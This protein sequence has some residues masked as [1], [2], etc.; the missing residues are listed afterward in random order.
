MCEDCI[1]PPVRPKD[2]IL[3]GPFLDH[4]HLLDSLGDCPAPASPLTDVGAVKVQ[5]AFGRA[6]QE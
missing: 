5:L 1:Q 6:R 2:T 3:K 4:F